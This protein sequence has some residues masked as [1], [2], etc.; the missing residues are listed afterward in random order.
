MRAGL[1]LPE[2]V[3][4][5]M[6]IQWYPGHMAKATRQ[7]QESLK[8]I[9]VVLEVRDARIPV[10]SHNVDLARIVGNRPVIIILARADLAD[11][12]VTSAWVKE[13]QSEG[14]EIVAVDLKSGQ[15]LSRVKE[16]IVRISARLRRQLEKQG[17]QG[18]A[19][20]GLVIGVPNVGKSTLINRLAGRTAARVGARPGVTRGKQWLKAG[21]WLQLLDTPGI[22]WPKFDHPRTGFYL[23]V[24]GALNDD[25]FDGEAVGAELA[26][27]LAQKWPAA[28]QQR[29]GLQEV[30]TEGYAVLT[31]IGR[32]RGFLQA[33]GK[34]DR[35]KAA[36]LLLREFRQGLLGRFSLEMP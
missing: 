18:R 10:S 4:L 31:V 8:V 20:R 19:V 27:L 23:A 34:V 11:P 28:L 33:G 7:I 30:P 15:G 16:V 25:V 12:T 3:A 5:P 35:V 6:D 9:D 26:A 1:I 36:H 13:L 14:G 21:P 22:L 2:E 17:R 32:R 29:Y 24:T